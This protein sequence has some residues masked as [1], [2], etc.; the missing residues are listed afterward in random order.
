MVL[1][2]HQHG[3]CFYLEKKLKYSHIIIAN[4]LRQGCTTYGPQ[5]ACSPLGLTVRSVTILGNN[6]NFKNVIVLKQYSSLTDSHLEDNWKHPFHIWPQNMTR[7][8]PKSSVISLIKFARWL[9]RPKMSSFT[10]SFFFFIFP[11]FIIKKKIMESFIFFNSKT[12][13]NVSCSEF[14]PWS[15]SSFLWSSMALTTF[16]V[17][18]ASSTMDLHVTITDIVM[19]CANKSISVLSSV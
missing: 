18:Q 12:I 2:S 16:C 7:L 1:K 17:V 8:L 6:I 11:C 4:T 14:T 10:G 15:Y 5:A 13:N 3:K 19:I 9:G